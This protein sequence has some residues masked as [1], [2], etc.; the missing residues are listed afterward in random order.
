M[1]TPESSH[2]ITIDN[3]IAVLITVGGFSFVQ[4]F[5]VI[6]EVLV[7]TGQKYLEHSA[8]SKRIEHVIRYLPNDLAVLFLIKDFI[9]HKNFRARLRLDLLV[10]LLRL[11]IN[12]IKYNVLVELY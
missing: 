11:I 5:V 12:V 6:Y 2:E 1:N 4:C 10:Y 9:K 3:M 8:V 7:M